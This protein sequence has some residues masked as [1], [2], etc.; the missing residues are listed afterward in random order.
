MTYFGLPPSLS[1]SVAA[2][3]SYTTSLLL[4]SFYSSSPKSISI[5]EGLPG[6]FYSSNALVNLVYYSGPPKAMSSSFLVIFGYGEQLLFD[7]IAEPIAAF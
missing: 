5:C 2:A 4:C 1:P 3:S 7:E 6:L